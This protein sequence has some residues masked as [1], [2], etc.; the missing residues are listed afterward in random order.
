MRK[1]FYPLLPLSNLYRLGL[2]ND[3]WCVRRGSSA[4]IVPSPLRYTQFCLGFLLSLSVI[5]PLSCCG[6][7]PWR[8]LFFKWTFSFV[9]Y[10]KAIIL[11][12][13]IHKGKEKFSPL[14]HVVFALPT[15]APGS[16]CATRP[17]P[18]SLESEDK[19]HTVIP[20]QFVF[21]AQLLAL[22]WPSWKSIHLSISYLR[23]SHLP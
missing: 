22:L 14:L 13:W 5:R 2:K 16:D 4:Q 15:F 8:G 10:L 7:F 12:E 18:A 21:L 17:L 20:I 1:A 11:Q 23:L 19:R 3:L 6:V 9:R